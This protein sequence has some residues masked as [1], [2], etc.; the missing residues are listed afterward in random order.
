MKT[1]V[2]R[3]RMR[4]KFASILCRPSWLLFDA[5]RVGFYWMRAEL[6][7]RPTGIRDNSALHRMR[8]ELSP[9]P[10]CHR[11]EL[12]QR[13]ELAHTRLSIPKQHFALLKFR[14]RLPIGP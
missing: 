2:A 12:A 13:A 7:R 8:A 5:G 1:C 11:A 10:S 6:S 14:N 3:L 4:A 9:G